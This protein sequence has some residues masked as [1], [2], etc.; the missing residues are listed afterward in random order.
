MK[1]EQGLS[2]MEII[3]ASFILSFAFVAIAQNHLLA[4][5]ASEQAY[6][7]SLTD[8]KNNE[9]AERLRSCLGNSSCTQL[10]EKQWQEEIST[11]LPKGKIELNQKCKERRIKIS[12]PTHTKTSRLIQISLAFKV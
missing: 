10:Q 3:V 11:L 1:K 6:F 5:R 8:L 4:L 2:F 7:V 12:W 9:L